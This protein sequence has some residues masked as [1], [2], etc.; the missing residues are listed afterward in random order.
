MVGAGEESGKLAESLGVV[1]SQLESSYALQKKIRGA[2]MY[3][4]VIVLALIGIGTFMLTYIVPT[5]IT[6]FNDIGSDLP[7]STKFLIFASG[8]LTNHA[9][10]FFGGL[11]VL[12]ILC[13]L[14]MRTPSGKKGKDFFVLHVPVVRTNRTNTFVTFEGWSFRRG[15]SHHYQGCASK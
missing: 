3:P 1:A 9:L 15:G 6:T 7:A 5:L 13:F 12:I 11:C 2:L 10:A 4:S 14:F 8:L